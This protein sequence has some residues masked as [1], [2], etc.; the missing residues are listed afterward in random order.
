MATP[1]HPPYIHSESLKRVYDNLALEAG[2]RLSLMTQAIAAESHNGTVSHL[3]CS[4]QKRP[5]RHHGARLH[6]LQRRR[7]SVRLGR[8][9]FREGRQGRHHDGR[10]VVQPLGRRRLVRRQDRPPERRASLPGH[11][12]ERPRHP[13]RARPAP[14]RHVAR[15]AAALPGAISAT[16]L[17][18][19]WPRRAVP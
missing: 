6:R 11:P 15:P 19:G 14:G 8:R 9:P 16:V 2:V 5:V 1:C 13:A 18:R 4:G 7:R 3:I 10:H 12:Q 17:R